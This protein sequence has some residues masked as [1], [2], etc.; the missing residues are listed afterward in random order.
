[1]QNQSVYPRLESEESYDD[2]NIGEEGLIGNAIR[3]FQSRRRH[4][5]SEHE[6]VDLLMAAVLEDAIRV[7]QT[8]LVRTAAPKRDDF[9]EAQ[10]WLFED[11]SDSPFSLHNICDLLELDPGYIR[12]R[13]R[14]WQ[15]TRLCSSNSRPTGRRKPTTYDR[16][17]FVASN[18]S[19]ERR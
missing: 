17:G 6:S 16:G 3:P 13:L 5:N 11:D 7:F 9:L 15:H 19:T 8:A 14:E 12:R 1:M 18:R 4:R 10:F 2:P